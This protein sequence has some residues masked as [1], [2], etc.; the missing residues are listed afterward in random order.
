MIIADTINGFNLTPIATSGGNFTYSAGRGGSGYNESG[1][2]AYNGGGGGR[3]G[4]FGGG[5]SGWCF[6]Y[7]NNAVNQDTTGTV[8]AN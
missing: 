6:I 1:N 8:L 2:G 3:A 5:S 4:G 7:C